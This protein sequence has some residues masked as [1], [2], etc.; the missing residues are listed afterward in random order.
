MQISILEK[1]SLEAAWGV[2]AGGLKGKPEVWDQLGELCKKPARRWQ[3]PAFRSRQ[4]Q[5]NGEEERVSRQNLQV[6]VAD[7][8]WWRK[9]SKP[10]SLF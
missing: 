7:Q 6:L 5:E 4:Q 2:A 8:T 9:K 1:M 10:Q 3:E